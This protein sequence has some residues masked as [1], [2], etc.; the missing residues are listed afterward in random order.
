MIKS[1]SDFYVI[2][3]GENKFSVGDYNSLFEE[4]YAF[5]KQAL[6]NKKAELK[7]IVVSHHV[8]TND[9]YPEKYKTSS[10]NEAFSVELTEFITVFSPNY[11]IY[12]HHHCNVEDFTLGKTKLLTNQLGYV[13]YG[14][15]VGFSHSK[16]V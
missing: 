2:Q 12:G 3:N 13:K 10:I 7:T 1:L 9:N 14:E 11:W 5:V 15:N 8:P 16:L 6:Q 4:N